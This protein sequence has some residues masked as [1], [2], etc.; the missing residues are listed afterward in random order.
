MKKL[1]FISALLLNL[2][3]FAYWGQEYDSL[4]YKGDYEKALR[5]SLEYQKTAVGNIR[6]AVTN[7][8]AQC[9]MNLGNVSEAKRILLSLGDNISSKAYQIRRD[10]DLAN[11]YYI[12]GNKDSMFLYL[13]R[14]SELLNKKEYS[15]DLWEQSYYNVNTLFAAYYD[16]QKDYTKEYESL[17]K[18]S[19]IDFTKRELKYLKPSLICNLS[20]VKLKLNTFNDNDVKSLDSLVYHCSN[21]SSVLIAIDLLLQFYKNKTNTPKIIEYYNFANHLK[22]SVS[23]RTRILEQTK[24]FSTFDVREKEYKIESLKKEKA[25]QRNLLIIAIIIICIALI[26]G[27][28]IFKLYRKSQEQKRII[29]E[30]Q[31]EVMDSIRYAK[32]IQTSLLP[33]EK[34][35]DKTLNRLMNK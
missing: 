28:I 9:Y 20:E 13:T 15:F 14:S 26:L 10:N 30:K 3:T 24:L 31:K 25:Y 17:I 23:N 4:M 35:I 11:V 1:L 29:E 5:I 6:V 27:A 2:N 34:Y 19:K 16:M 21:E 33:T 18:A 7:N 8:I 12:Q 22:D 32:R